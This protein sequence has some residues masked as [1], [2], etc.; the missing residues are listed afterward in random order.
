MWKIFICLLVC[1]CVQEVDDPARIKQVVIRHEMP[2]DG[3]IE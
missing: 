1:S 3:G 2:L